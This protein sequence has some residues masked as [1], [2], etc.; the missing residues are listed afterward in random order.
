[1]EAILYVLITGIQWRALSR[2]YGP[3]TTAHGRFQEWA[4]DGVFERLWKHA[5]LHYDD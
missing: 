2:C 5:I 3:A 4:Q 1:M